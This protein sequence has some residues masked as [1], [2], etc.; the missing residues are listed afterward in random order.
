[1]KN[2]TMMK[3]MDYVLMGQVYYLIRLECWWVNKARVDFNLENFCTVVIISDIRC[4]ILPNL[5]CG[6][7]SLAVALP[8]KHGERWQTAPPRHSPP[9]GG[10]LMWYAEQS[11]S[12]SVSWKMLGV[13]KPPKY[14]DWSMLVCP[15]V[16]PATAPSGLF[17]NCS[18][19]LALGWSD[20]QRLCLHCCFHDYDQS[21]RE[22]SDSKEA[23]IRWRISAKTKFT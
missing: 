20:C 2:G 15:A 10:A 12:L 22:N 14:T 13:F 11:F 19:W 1:M 4:I 3:E 8:H 18:R 6:W 21:S 23:G 7:H 9:R 16:S 5:R 17:E